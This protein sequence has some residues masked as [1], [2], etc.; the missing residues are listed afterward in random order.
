[1]KVGT[2]SEGAVSEKTTDAPSET[3]HPRTRSTRKRG[4]LHARMHSHPVLSV[5]TKVGVTVVGTVVL[6]IGI[7]MIVTPGP[8]LVMIPLGLAILSTEW[9]WAEKWL[10]KARD[11][12]VRAK[13]KA[14]A[15]DPRTRRR[16]LV[17]SG[18]AVIVAVALVAGYVTIYDWPWFAI[19]AWDWAQATAGWL[20]DLPG[21]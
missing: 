2:S 1:M 13:E 17:L 3:E 8:A 18:V 5:V 12:A 20:P 16:R 15:M 9:H 11:E 7:I 10:K 21:M 14:E 6:I 4:R 19:K